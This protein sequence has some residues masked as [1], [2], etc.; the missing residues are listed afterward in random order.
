MHHITLD[1]ISIRTDIRPGDIG[2]V[3]YRHGVLYKEEYQYGMEFESYVAYG[4]HEFIK[5]YDPKTNR[6]WIAEHN[7]KI[8]GFVLLMNRGDAAQLR[9]FIVEPEYRGIGLG[10][11]LMEL[12]MEF[13]RYCNYRSSFLWTTKELESASS[14]YKLYGFTL[15]EEKLSAAFGKN[16]IEQRY[17]LMLQ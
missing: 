14:L 11:K 7:G 2:F 8:V 10:K 17:D 6:A 1:D 5:H 9:Y 3:I 16:V 4:L 15:V 12:Y 13:L